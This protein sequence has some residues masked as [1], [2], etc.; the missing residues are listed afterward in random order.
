MQPF[1]LLLGL[2]TLAGLLLAGWRAPQ[3]ATIRY[4]DASV[5]VLFG[6]LLGSRAVS[7]AV[8]WGYY[9]AHLGEII[10]V[11]LGGLSAIGALAGGV[12]AVFI[13]A[14]WLE[15]P[16]GALADVLLPLAGSITVT[17]WLGC[18]MGS[19][20]YGWPSNLV[21][22]LP[23]HDEWGVLAPRIPV[24]L[25]GAV[26][27]LIFFWWLDS[28][29]KRLTVPGLSASFGLFGLAALLF[30]L[31]Y[32]RADPVPVWR[33]LRLEAWGAVGLMIISAVF[34][35]ACLVRWRLKKASLPAR[36]AL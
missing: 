16:V 30:G 29:S 31:S 9:S 34:I 7:V 19:C 6:S 27:T 21:F 23:S 25:V 24:Q 4:V 22:A 33:G 14:I 10:Q 1:S 8:N 35:L 20:A 13:V 5:L 36:R 26:L 3:K 2:G 15:L 11:W 12:L 17:S 28:A 18:W 32:L